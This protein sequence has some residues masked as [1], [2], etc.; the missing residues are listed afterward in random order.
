MTEPSDPLRKLLAAGRLETC[1]RHIRFPLLRNVAE[2][3]IIQFTYPIAA[4][5]GSNG[6]NKT[7]ILR[8]LQ[9]CPDYENLGNHWSSIDLDP[10]S[11]ES[12]FRSIHGY[13]ARSQG[14]V[15]EAIKSRIAWGT[16]PA[17]STRNATG[18]TRPSQASPDYFAPSRPILGDGME[19]MPAVGEGKELPP[20]RVKTRWKAISKRAVYL[21]FRFELSAFDRYWFHVPYSSRVPNLKAKKALIRRRSAHLAGAVS[22]GADEGLTSLCSPPPRV[23]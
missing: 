4:L 21:D 13:I 12:R 19:R 15:V 3:T 7:A 17:R 8:A 11:P 10:I 23:P 14:R 22:N 5:V 1:I 16:G 18:S 9:D 20:E 2:G 6:T